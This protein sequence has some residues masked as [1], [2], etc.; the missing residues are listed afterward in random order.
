[1]LPAFLAV[2][3]VV[4]LATGCAGIRGHGEKSDLQLQ[5]VPYVE[6]EYVG[7]VE[8]PPGIPGMADSAALTPS[9]EPLAAAYSRRYDISPELARDIVEQ[10]LEAGI[11]PELAFRVIRVESVFNI[12]ARGPQGSLGLMQLMPGTA[13][14]LDRSLD[15][16]GEILEPRNN[17]RVGLRYLRSLIERYN[18]VRLG[19]LAYNRGENAVNR[20]LRRGVDPENGY[21]HKVLGTHSD[22]PY[23]GPG[24]LSTPRLP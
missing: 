9:G 11:D 4:G 7:A 13:R 17:L 8:V 3:S 24:I 10:A 12:R 20:A 1:M 19:L 16:E 21:T 2:V 5:P 6:S 18:D 14:S 23:S 22:N 15:S